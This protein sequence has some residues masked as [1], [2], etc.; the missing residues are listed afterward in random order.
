M[1][2]CGHCSELKIKQRRIMA[3]FFHGTSDCAQPRSNCASYVMDML[4]SAAEVCIG[5]LHRLGCTL[6]EGWGAPS[7]IRQKRGQDMKSGLENTTIVSNAGLRASLDTH[8]RCVNPFQKIAWN[9]C[10]YVK[11]L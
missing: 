9:M 7:Q 4:V 3:P 8:R 2:E 6:R 1:N 5:D 10:D 11:A